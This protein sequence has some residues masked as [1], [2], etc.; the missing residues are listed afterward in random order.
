MQQAAFGGSLLHLLYMDQ[1]SFLK[2]HSSGRLFLYKAGGCLCLPLH[3]MKH[4]HVHTYFS[5]LVLNLTVTWSVLTPF[6]CHF[7]KKEKNL[8]DALILLPSGT[9]VSM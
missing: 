4:H 5:S 3:S 1:N 9:L 6:W 7:L 8:P 2:N